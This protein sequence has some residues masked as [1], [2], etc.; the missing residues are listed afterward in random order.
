MRR[1]E[2]ALKRAKESAGQ[3]ME[4]AG[5]TV[6]FGVE[7]ARS[8]LREVGQDLREKTEQVRERAREVGASVKQDVGRA[9]GK[10]RNGLTAGRERVVAAAQTGEEYVVK[11][12][13]KSVLAAFGVGA[14]LGVAF[15]R[16]GA[17]RGR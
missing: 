6:D 3:T 14:L 2:L 5:E 8:G 17:R 11:N 15:G 16:I 1:S 12:P 9:A 10:V 7:A 13:K 4:S